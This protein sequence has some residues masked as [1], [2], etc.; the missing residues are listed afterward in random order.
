MF[1]CFTLQEQNIGLHWAAYSGCQDVMEV[2]LNNNKDN[3]DHLNALN[4]H[5]DTPL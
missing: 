2:F 4:V 3:T 5:G 1:E